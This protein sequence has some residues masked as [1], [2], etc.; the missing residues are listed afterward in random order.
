MFGGETLAARAHRL[1]GEACDEV[2]AVGK[3]GDGLPF[4]VV[5][6]GADDRAPVL[7]VIAGLRLTRDVAVVL[8]VDCPLVR[9]ETLRA[10]GEAGAVPSASIPLPGAYPVSLLP[11]LEERVAG[12]VVTLRGVNPVTLDV[13]PAELVDVD[14]VDDLERLRSES[15]F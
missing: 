12:G 9:P 7:G 11:V 10:L 14:T 13:D 1:L 4:P 6:D 3:A 5:D 8:P 15:S 2:I